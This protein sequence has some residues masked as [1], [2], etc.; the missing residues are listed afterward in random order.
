MKQRTISGIILLI[1]LIG[2]LV[3]SS[4]LFAI[5]MTGAAVIGFNEF[6]TVKFGKNN[7]LNVIKILGML[8]VIFI[9]LNN[10]FYKVELNVLILIPILS[11]SLPMLL[12]NNNKVYNIIDSLFVIGIVYFIGLSF[13]NII[14]MREKMQENLQKKMGIKY[15]H[16]KILLK[17]LNYLQEQCLKW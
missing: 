16:I 6:F 4:Q 17:N 8:L 2:S 11:L 14:L 13:G 12:Y 10:I 7:E 1:V 9:T 5:L 15:L 3:I